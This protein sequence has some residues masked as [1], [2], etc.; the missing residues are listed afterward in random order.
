[1][2]RVIQP[3]ANLKLIHEW[4]LITTFSKLPVSSIA[5][6]FKPGSSILNNAKMHAKSRYSVRVD[7][8]S[9]FPSIKAE[10]FSAVIERCLT[11]LPE[12]AAQ[13]EFMGLVTLACFDKS[14]RLPIGYPTSPTIANAVMFDF[15][16]RLHEIVL[17]QAD[18]YGDA[19]LSR[20][21]DDFVFSTNKIGACRDFVDLFR[22][23]LTETTAPALAINEDKTRYMSRAGG[24]ALVT[25]LKINEQGEVRVH[26]KYRDHVRLLLKLYAT[27]KLSIESLEQLRG[28]LAFVE[29]ADPK[30][31]T[32]LA[33][34]YFGQI[35]S[36][37]APQS[38]QE[39][40]AG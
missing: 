27:H 12:I 25:G 39:D 5:T 18:I 11:D 17:S 38:Q 29:F 15:D 7:L 26:P 9:F 35:E 13:P 40:P 22:L 30:L 31:F 34:R 36:L 10:D 16:Q 3:T 2:R 37:R 1:M 8:Q 4:L 32:R 28:H 33:F 14:D 21:A 19:R 24:S 6:A 20:Y 23:R